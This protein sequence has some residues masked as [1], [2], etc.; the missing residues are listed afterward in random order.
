MPGA[1]E[2]KHNYHAEAT[3]LSGNLLLPVSQ[4]IE[5]QT[6]AKL[7]PKGGYFA[8]RSDGYRLESVISYRSASSH[9]AGNKSNKPGEGWNTLTTTVVEGLNVME[10]L[11][12][13]R[14]VGQTI[15]QH[16]LKGY[17]PSI[18]FLGTRFEN[19]RIAGIPVELEWDL[20]IFGPMPI[21]DMPYALEAGVVSRVSQ[22]YGRI[23]RNKNL[24]DALQ[25]RYN[26]LSSTL[27]SAEAI[28]CSLVN[29]VAGLFPG[30]IAGNVITIPG[31]GTITLGKLTVKHEDPIASAKTHKKT[32]FTLT[33]IDL[34]LGC[35]IEGRVPIGD[36]SS[37]GTTVP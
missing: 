13:D 21:N 4:T 32:T 30:T 1:K 22:Q 35:V 31:F 20:G 33:M 8:Q 14:I 2:R 24:P 28:E 10:V 37:N 34:N 6:H 23:L 11:T 12:A 16:P 18:S 15:T 27:G 9:V 29:R 3:V 36:G 26:R 5:T 7:D 25:E 19:L 17:M